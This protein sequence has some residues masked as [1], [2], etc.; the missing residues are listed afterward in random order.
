MTYKN[1]QHIEYYDIQ[2]AAERTISPPANFVI[3]ERN[4]M[5]PEV[6]I[7]TKKNFLKRIKYIFYLQT[8]IFLGMS[9]N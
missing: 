3:T 8:Y 1:G 7:F 6:E 4:E 9:T 5:K 2:Y